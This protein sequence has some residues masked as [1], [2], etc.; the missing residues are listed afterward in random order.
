M[1]H[2]QALDKDADLSVEGI[3]S[4]LPH[5]REVFLGT[6]S[7]QT[8]SALSSYHSFQTAVYSRKSIGEYSFLT[9]P[10]AP[11]DLVVAPFDFTYLT[12]PSTYVP[13]TIL[14]MG[15][16]YRL[17]QTSKDTNK[18][19]SKN[20]TYAYDSA[21]MTGIS[22]HAG[23]GEEAIFRGFYLPFFHQQFGENFLASNLVTSG[24]FALAHVSPSLPFPIVQFG[25]GYYFGML[26]R[27]N[28]WDIRESAFLHTWW[29]AVIFLSE[30]YIARRS[31]NATDSAK[32]ITM[33]LFNISF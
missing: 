27:D 18:S 5:L 7:A 15:F 1:D 19:S 3:T 24:L 16:G 33:E 21:L 6:K 23:V 22:Y 28:N 9:S 2:K 10:A 29:D 14:A 8:F 4:T 30:M 12:R 13:L 11:L 32:P 31:P 20:S 26:T 17:Y 25:L